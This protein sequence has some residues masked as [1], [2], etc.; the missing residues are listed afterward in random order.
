M[1]EKKIYKLAEEITAEIK[2][3]EGG[4]EWEESKL[5]INTWVF[6]CS[7]D[8]IKRKS[9]GE[10]VRDTYGKKYTY[11][12]LFADFLY[13]FTCENIKPSIK[14]YALMCLFSIKLRDLVLS[15]FE[16]I[17]TEEERDTSAGKINNIPYSEMTSNKEKYYLLL[18]GSAGR[19]L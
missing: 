14:P 10:E 12:K 2:S 13:Y 15:L 3:H 5:Y 9:Q 16:E 11:K 6:A 17:Y 4:E 1:N 19:V 18:L 7:L 8:L